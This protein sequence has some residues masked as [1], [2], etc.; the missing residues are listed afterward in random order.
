MGFL[1]F[2]QETGLAGG[3]AGG[4]VALDPALAKAIRDAP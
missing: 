4:G 1:T 3:L 2:F